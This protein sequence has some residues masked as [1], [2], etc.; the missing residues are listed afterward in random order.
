MTNNQ[1]LLAAIENEKSSLELA[2]RTLPS[3]TLPAFFPDRVELLAKLKA[4]IEA[5][6]TETQATIQDQLRKHFESPVS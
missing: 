4:A 6:D 2:I 1:F 3:D 5:N